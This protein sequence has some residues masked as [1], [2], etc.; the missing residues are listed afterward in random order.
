MM[1][2]SAERRGYERQKTCGLRH[3][4]PGIGRNSCTESSADG[5]NLCHRQ[6]HQPAPGEGRGGRSRRILAGKVP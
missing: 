1:R 3:D 2:A 5:R 4:V 6:G